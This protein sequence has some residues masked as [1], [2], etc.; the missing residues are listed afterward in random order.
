VRP[1]PPRR[2]FF[3]DRSLGRRVVPEALRAIGWTIRTMH[4]VYGARDEDVPD[5]EW[6]ERC[7]REGWVALSKD[8]NIRHN[9][10]ERAAVE[11]HAVRMF[12]IA[13]GRLTGGQQAERFVVNAERILDAC[14]E[15]GPF[16]YVVHS[17]GIARLHPRAEER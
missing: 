11:A 8:K 13:S 9:P 17:H 16:I 2:E 10:L 15:R 3:L 12:V 6:L 1:S 5:V 7:G 4:E 14:E